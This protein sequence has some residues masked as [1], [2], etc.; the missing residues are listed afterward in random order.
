MK[1]AFVG[2]GLMLLP[3][4][5]QA[6]SAQSRPQDTVIRYYNALAA[7]DYRAAYALWSEGGQASGQTFVAFKAGFAQTRST[8]VWVTGLAQIEGA[9]GSL[10]A[11][12]PVRVKAQLNDGR[13]Q[14]F[15]GSYVLRKNNTGTGDPQTWNWHL[16]RGMLRPSS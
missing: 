16:Y 3:L 6:Q 8:Y 15:A 11:T 14:S 2:F 1:Q 5:A 10:Y 13:W 12:V 7:R 4:P 9:A